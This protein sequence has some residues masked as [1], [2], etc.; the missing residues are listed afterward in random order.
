ME[1]SSAWFVSF[2]ASEMPSRRGLI[3]IL[4]CRSLEDRER[5]KN[6]IVALPEGWELLETND[7]WT[8]QK[9]SSAIFPEAS[10]NF[11]FIME[12]LPLET[13]GRA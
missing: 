10:E 7:A 8:S 6:W 9:R 11:A 1:L 5:L 13:K 2:E 4:D 12:Q 3:W